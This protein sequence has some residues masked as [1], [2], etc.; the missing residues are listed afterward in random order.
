MRIPWTILLLF[1]SV[2]AQAPLASFEF[3][4]ASIKP[5]KSLNGVTGGCHARD[6]HF[7]A[8]DSRSRCSSSSSSVRAANRCSTSSSA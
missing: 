3:E 7:A 8:T 1:V 2:V 6:A 4:A 5:T